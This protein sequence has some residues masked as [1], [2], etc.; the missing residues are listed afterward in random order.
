MY[1]TLTRLESNKTGFVSLYKFDCLRALSVAVLC[2]SARFA[3]RMKIQQ[4]INL[5][6]VVKLKKNSCRNEEAMDA[7]EN[8]HITE[9]E[10]MR[11]E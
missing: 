1:S 6:F 11:N 10:E 9:N 2:C 5:K 3:T 7:L 4:H 8:T